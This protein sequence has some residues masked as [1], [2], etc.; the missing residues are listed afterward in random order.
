MI[1]H[2]RTDSVSNVGDVYN[3]HKY[4]EEIA[5][6]GSVLESVECWSAGAQPCFALSSLLSV[7]L[8]RLVCLCPI[9]PRFASPSPI[10]RDPPHMGR[11]YS[12]CHVYWIH[13]AIV[14]MS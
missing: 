5:N 11:T 9:S 10:A 4:S 14:L 2:K 12:E 3:V 7:S 6:T 1:S 13:G 8:S